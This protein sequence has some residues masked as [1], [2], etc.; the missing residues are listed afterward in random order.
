MIA[1]VE[2]YLQDAIGHPVFYVGMAR[3]E[4]AEVL[5]YLCIAEVNITAQFSTVEVW[6]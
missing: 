3:Y 1:I 4:L 2:T 6:L 5:S